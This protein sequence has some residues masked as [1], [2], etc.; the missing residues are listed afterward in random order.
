LD[1]DEKLGGGGIVIGKFNLFTPADE[2]DWED[3]FT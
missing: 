3:K 2:L 1:K